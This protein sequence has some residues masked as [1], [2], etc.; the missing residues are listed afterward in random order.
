MPGPKRKIYRGGYQENHPE[1]LELPADASGI[2]PGNLLQVTAGELALHGADADYM[3]VAN[4][5]P[6]MDPLD[7]VYEEGETVFGYT[8][9]SREVYLVRAAGG[10]TGPK[11][12]P[13]ASNAN[14][15]VIIAT[16]EAAIVGYLHF[17]VPTAATANDLIDMRIK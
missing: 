1:V 3:Y 10:L 14:G 7:Y 15:Q 12:A 11:D 5:P 13:L 8:P 9:R 17:A 2:L 4:C 16:G 6:C